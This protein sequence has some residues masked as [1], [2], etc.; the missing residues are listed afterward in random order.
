MAFTRDFSGSA[1]LSDFAEFTVLPR[2]LTLTAFGEP[3]EPYE[4]Y[5]PYR[6][7]NFTDLDLLDTLGFKAFM[8]IHA[9]QVFKRD[10]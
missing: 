3:Y 9:G 5:R 4:P 8:R 7:Y 6:P 1:E 2:L 10:A